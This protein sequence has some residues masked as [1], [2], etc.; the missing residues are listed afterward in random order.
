VATNNGS[1]GSLVTTLYI[2]DVDA[3]ANNLD[4]LLD[5]VIVN[6][7]IYV[8]FENGTNYAYQVTS[9]TDSGQYHTFGV[10]YLSGDG[11]ISPI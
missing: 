10:T 1:I 3:D 11:D 4:A 5:Q 8:V 9:N 2:A 7:I 6:S